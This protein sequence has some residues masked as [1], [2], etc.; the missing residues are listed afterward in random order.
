MDPFAYELVQDG[1]LVA[2]RAAPGDALATLDRVDRA[3]DPQTLVVADAGRAAGIAGI[4]GGANTEIRASTRR[5]LLEAASWHPPLIRRTG[6]RLGV[7]TESGARFERGIDTGAVLSASLRA[8]QL[9]Q[10]VAGGRV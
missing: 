8:Q 4:I 9:I 5:V 3:L 10:E 2:G 6:K 1:P 7:R